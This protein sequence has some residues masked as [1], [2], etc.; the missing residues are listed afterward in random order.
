MGKNLHPCILH[1]SLRPEHR[2]CRQRCH[3]VLIG[4]DAMAASRLHKPALTCALSR[5]TTSLEY[6]IKHYRWA[7]ADGSEPLLRF[8]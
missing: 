7:M 8:I 1:R 3:E 5:L 6:P 2:G 4:L